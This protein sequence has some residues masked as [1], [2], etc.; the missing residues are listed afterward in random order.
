M[1]MREKVNKVNP[2]CP[3]NKSWRKTCATKASFAGLLDDSFQKFT[4]CDSCANADRNKGWSVP[5]LT[6]ENTIR[7]DRFFGRRARPKEGLVFVYEARYRRVQGCKG[8]ILTRNGCV[9]LLKHPARLIAFSRRSIS[10]SKRSLIIE[11][12][13]GEIHGFF[14]L[15]C[16]RILASL[17]INVN[18]AKVGAR[19]V[20]VGID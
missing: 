3:F 18:Q 10:V 5:D 4:T 17:F 1:R 6:E 20:E 16:H 2:N 15:G 19:E 12:A 9:Q 7:I 8:H 14:E 11:A 13:S